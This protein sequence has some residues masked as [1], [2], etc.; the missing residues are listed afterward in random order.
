MILL[1]VPKQ[2]FIEESL[3]FSSLHICQNNVDINI[4]LGVGRGK[5]A[6]I[7]G[8][9]FVVV[10]LFSRIVTCSSCILSL[11]MPSSGSALDFLPAFL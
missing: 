9:T 10:R 11:T 3:N 6:A 2:A 5:T 1:C 7:A 8:L 4:A